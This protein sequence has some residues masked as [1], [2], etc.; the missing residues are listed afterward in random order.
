MLASKFFD[1]VVG[2][3]IHFELTPFGVPAP[4]PNPFIGLIFDPMGLL[5]GQAM[6]Y[7][8][9]LATGTVPTGPVL[10][11]SVPAANVGTEAKNY[12]GVPHI[13]IP[14][15][16]AWAPMPKQPKP[17]F[18]G[19]PD[20]PG[21]PIA[22]EGDAVHVFGSQSVNIMGSSAVRMGDYAM[23]CGEP[24]RLPS[25]VAMA[26]PL[27]APVLIGGPPALSLADAAGALVKTKWVA[28]H[29]HGL[30]SRLKSERLRN[31]LSKAV[32][33]LT[34]H[35]VDVATGRVL[36]DAL[37]FELP[38]ALPLRLERHYSSAWA[39]RAGPLGPGW[40]HSLDQA[41]WPERGRIVYLDAEGREL[42]F[43]TFAFPDHRLPD[44][45]EVYEPIS[46]LT[47]RSLG[48]GRYTLTTHDGLEREFARLAPPAARA[49]LPAAPRASWSRLLRER[50]RAG[51][52]LDYRY[53]ER[54]L[55]ASV[56]GSGG[57][58]ALFEH[59]SRGRLL[60]T[61]LPDPVH[62]ERWL[63]HT[64]Y[65]YDAEGDLVTASDALGHS[66]RYAYETHL[67][68]AETNRNGLSFYFAYD[69]FG[70]DAYCVRTW[71][72]GGLYDHLISY[73]KAGR[74]T[75]V[76]NS[77][78]FTTSY[79]MHAIG[80]VTKV[81]D[82]LG[83]TTQYEYDEASLQR[84]KLIDPMGA[85]SE[86]SYDS[87]G[88]CIQM[89][90]PDGARL[91]ITYDARNLPEQL[92]DALGGTWRWKYD[93]DGR[94]LARR[95]PLAQRT[96]FHWRGP[97]LVGVTDPAGQLTRLEYD[98]ADNL[99]ALVPPDG[100]TTRWAYDA[101]GRCV[102]LGDPNGNEQRRR[103]DALGRVVRV[104]EPD[105][106]IRDLDYDPEGNVI[107]ARDR[108]HDVRF[109]YQGLSRLA[110]R[111]EAGTRI[112]FRYDSE[113]RLL[114]IQ[115]EHGAVYRFQLDPAGNVAEEHGFDGLRRRYQRDKAGRVQLI[116]RPASASSKYAYD[117]AGRVTLV[118]HSDGTR[119]TFAYR[120][121][122]EL[123]RATN[124]A[125][126]LQFERDP[127]GRILQELQGE[128]WLRSSYDALGRRTSLRSSKGLEQRIRRGALGDVQAIEAGVHSLRPTPTA[129]PPDLLLQERRDPYRVD[130]ERD[131]LG[132]ELQ[133]S[134]PGGVQARWQRDRLGR[135]ALH[136][137]QVHGVVHNARKYQW[138]TND[139]LRGIIDSQR[140]PS[141]FTHDALGN[142]AAATHADGRVEWRLPDAVGNLFQSRDRS[143][144]KYGPAGQLLEASDARGTTRYAYDPEG[145]LIEKLEPGG[146][147][148]A[149]RW[150][151]AGMLV[152]VERPDGHVVAFA[153]DALG[154]R[155][156]KTFRGKT[157][158]W[159][160]DGNVPL[161]EW[162]TLDDEA[163][164]RDGIPLRSSAE[165][166]IALGKRRA[167][168]A[169]RS[170]QGPPP[171]QADVPLREV[172]L[173]EGTPE[174]PITWLFEPESF[175]PLAKL[176]S[177][178]RYS[179]VTDHL[180]TP[181][182]M[183]DER[184]SESWAAE[185][186]TYGALRELRGQRCACP[187][188]FPG[189]YED[190][191][192]GLYY[193]RFRYYDPGTGGYVSRDPI[194][195]LGGKAPYAYAHD[196]LAWTDPSGLA[197]CRDV[198]TEP[199][200]A[201]FWSGRTGGVGGA[202]VAKQIAES[203][204]GTTLEMLTKQRGI[205]M[206]DWDPNNPI[207]VKAWSDMSHAYAAG[208]S[209]E[210]RAVIGK[211]LR[212]GNVWESHEIPALLDN[213]KVSKITTIDPKTLAESTIF[214]RAI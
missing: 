1:P 179:I 62:A 88:N 5:V 158:H 209:G 116:L 70:Q 39:N 206:P 177:D 55:L 204:G 14:P 46:R 29:L 59:D 79:F 210:V 169:Q 38:G 142:L 45:G 134:L 30:L 37:D 173:L 184:G 26:I 51:A 69:G 10:I 91:Q 178:E 21:L 67:L 172:P 130:F 82:P 114:A 44:G 174:S 92:T 75:F 36:T 157:S 188:R 203:R 11:N 115:N 193:N 129:T 214:V 199:N 126:E 64:R 112:E 13:L 50:T 145:N 154:R 77:L 155:I 42:E 195:L 182:A 171:G 24:V 32:C 16:V 83:N 205:S 23:S 138:E 143:D 163:L 15:G 106:N 211:N 80:A 22:P 175:A 131:R 99:S 102:T 213:P 63:V 148:W 187:F 68:T 185:I 167:L 109:E 162:I 146:K 140:G 159:I 90:A 120:A 119:E 117:K 181:R 152:E 135:P 212:A 43:D 53:D 208:V 78:G 65:A 71:G 123:I 33:F 25:S 127:L 74:A 2:V 170:A 191:E 103:Y 141:Q 66:F 97:L 93:G 192:T 176:V 107:Q 76:K 48:G 160:W 60:A 125:T 207:V 49:A 111:S 165:R 190:E 144:R 12:L 156:G 54:G 35:P 85:R 101:R 132:L 147:R 86:W 34:G 4:F 95:D 7:A 96:Q 189:Q 133:R 202:E 73:D 47:L 40:S 94:L 198:S 20:P 19:P 41:V 121:D 139:R 149:Y 104:D 6:G 57:R 28:G 108:D 98:A 61:R 153:Y 31:L 27:G 137:I 168:L 122:G 17:S 128:H 89:L 183:Y 124:A 150:N 56:T 136:E 113:E 194:G 118:E 164:A 81:I 3:D 72:D 186:D 196:P 161:H 180:G 200:T 9:A 18:K 52:S 151:L 105:G 58:S 84:T 100:S 8:V 197:G 87:R 201:F 110:A 166:E